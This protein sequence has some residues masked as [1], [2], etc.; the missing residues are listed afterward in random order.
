M[1]LS[2]DNGSENFVA[3]LLVTVFLGPEKE[4]Q[5]ILGYVVN[6]EKG[7]GIESCGVRFIILWTNED[8]VKVIDGMTVVLE[9]RIGADSFF[10]CPFVNVHEVDCYLKKSITKEI[11]NYLSCSNILQL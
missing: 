7:S 6:V 8:G 9:M 5:G 3:G 1:G 4:K 11:I 2:C 10:G